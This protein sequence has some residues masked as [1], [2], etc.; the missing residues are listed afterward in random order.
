MSLRF[1]VDARRL[2][3]FMMA[4]LLILALPVGTAAAAS[5]KGGKEKRSDRQSDGRT[6]SDGRGSEGKKNLVAEV[7]LLAPRLGLLSPRLGLLVPRLRVSVPR[8]RK[9]RPQG[10]REDS[11]RNDLEAREGLRAGGRERW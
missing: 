1:G 4:L 3:C 11:D 5:S 2:I 6:E 8:W 9:R 10:F 7:G